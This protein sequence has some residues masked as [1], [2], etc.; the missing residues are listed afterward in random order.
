[1]QT[2]TQIM[3]LLAAM[4]S[5]TVQAGQLKVFCMPIDGPFRAGLLFDQ[6]QVPAPPNTQAGMPYLA[7][8][9]APQEVNGSM[10]SVRVHARCTLALPDQAVQMAAPDPAIAELTALLECR[11]T[12]FTMEQSPYDM[13]VAWLKQSGAIRVK[14]QEP[15]G[16]GEGDTGGVIDTYQ[17]TQPVT[18]FGQEVRKVQVAYVSND[19]STADHTFI[20]HFSQPV[21]VI[22]KAASATPA[23]GGKYFMRKINDA[24]SLTVDRQG[25]G[26][27]SICQGE[28]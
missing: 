7:S 24:W 27:R 6:N 3:L 16:G 15:Q 25:G 18:V 10:T 19:D 4:T 2:S 13:A 23:K 9:E 1:M 17:M 8:V 12:S 11:K 20:A 22:A 5:T 28:L 14:H 21:D 26:T